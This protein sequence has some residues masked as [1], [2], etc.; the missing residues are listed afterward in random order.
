MFPEKQNLVS[1][2]GCEKAKTIFW[3]R[4]C[5]GCRFIIP[6]CSDIKIKINM[7]K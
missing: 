1:K 6:V 3:E 7:L 2:L 4:K 5:F